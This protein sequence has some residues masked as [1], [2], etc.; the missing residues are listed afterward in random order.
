MNFKE[1]GITLIPESFLVNITDINAIKKM[2]YS[3]SDIKKKSLEVRGVTVLV[4]VL[5]TEKI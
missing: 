2:G 5:D 4:D 1:E 3:D